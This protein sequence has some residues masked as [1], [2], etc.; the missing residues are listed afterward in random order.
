MMNGLR[1]HADHNTST[2]RPIVGINATTRGITSA[3]PLGC[4][5]ASVKTETSPN[6]QL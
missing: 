4:V 5:T 3:N 1:R 6:E 2:P